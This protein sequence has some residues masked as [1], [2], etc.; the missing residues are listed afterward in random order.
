MI[1]ELGPTL[2]LHVNLAKCEM[3]SRQD[4]TSFPP[5]VRCSLRPNLDI[6]GAPIGDYLHCSK[7]IAGRCAESR[8]LF[9]GLED[10]AAVHLQV[11]VSL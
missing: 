5:E 4:N 2:G 9:S 1:E 8:K 6:L 11:A 3:F 7:F 10:A